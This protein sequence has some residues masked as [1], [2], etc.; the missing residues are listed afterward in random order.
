MDGAGDQLLAD[1]AL[2]ADQHGGP[3]RGRAAD[4][5]FDLPHQ[6]AGA[7]DLALHAQPLAEL[8]VLVANLVEILGQFLLAGE[9]FEGHRHRVGH[10]ER[11]LQIVGVHALGGV[12]RIEMHDAQHLAFAADRGADH[13]RGED[14]ALRVAAAELAVVHHVAGQH[15]LAVAHH[16]RRQKLRDAVVAM[17]RIA[18][19]GDDLQPIGRLLVRRCAGAEQ[20]GAGVDLRAF[21]ESVERDVGQRNDVGRLGELEGETA[22]VRGGAA[23]L[24]QRDVGL[25][26]LRR[27]D[28]ETALLAAVR[29]RRRFVGFE[30]ALGVDLVGR[31]ATRLAVVDRLRARKIVCESGNACD[32]SWTNASCELPI[33]T[34]SPGWSV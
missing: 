16:G 1:A 24:W 34:T 13:A 33:R 15:R 31:A 11:E 28:E 6:I 18:P 22:E 2:A 10:G 12:G 5:L 21:E 25:F 20:H 4:F 9:I 14:V 7:D 17:G 32:R 27:L 3:A 19:R 26:V 30:H 8:D 23:D 29:D